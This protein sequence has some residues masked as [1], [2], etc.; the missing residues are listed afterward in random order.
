MPLRKTPA[1][2]WYERKPVKKPVRK[3]AARKR[4]KR[5]KAQP[6]PVMLLMY[7]DGKSAMEVQVSSVRET[8]R[9]ID[10]TC[11]SMAGGYYAMPG[12]VEL[13]IEAVGDPTYYWTKRSM[14]ARLRAVLQGKLMVARKNKPNRRK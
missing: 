9:P 4:A 6:Y 5:I 2:M 1:L 8:H 3:V 10:I 14:R 11:M 13:T 12:P 7:A